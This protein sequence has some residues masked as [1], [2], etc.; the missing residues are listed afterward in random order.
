MPAVRVTVAVPCFNEAL[1]IAK[2]VTDFKRELP[3]ARLLVV[4]NASTDGSGE[5]AR[6]AGAEVVHEARR[7]K[8]VVV[9]RILREATGDACVIV[10]VQALMAPILEGRADMA[11]G[12]RLGEASRVALTD[13]RRWGNHLILG[14]V[15]LAAGARYRDV[16]SGYRVLSRHFMASVPLSAE[17]FEIETELA[18]AARRCGMRVV[19]VRARYRA[20]PE[21]SHSKLRPLQDG[22]RIA[23]VLLRFLVAP[24]AARG[25]ARRPAAGEQPPRA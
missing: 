2:V 10:D 9:R 25:G 4:D 15:N 24:P 6:A 5:L 21:G 19:E 20:R 16:L 1:T 22:L 7:G 3:D 11:V 23:R 18:L 8:G 12:D 13:V 14:A 17:G